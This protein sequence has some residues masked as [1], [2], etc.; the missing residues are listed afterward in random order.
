V[1][2]QVGLADRAREHYR[3]Y[4]LG[5][6]QRLA[7]GA[8][9]LKSPDLLILDEP[10]N[11]LDPAGIRSIRE[12]IRGLGETGTT[13]LLSSHILTEVQQV[14]HSVSILG[15]GRMLASGPVEELLGETVA[16]IR[17]GVSDPA[18]AQPVLEKAGHT[19]TRKGDLLLV[20]GP[21]RPEEITRLL[22]GQGIYVHEIAAVKPTLESFFLKLTGKRPEPAPAREEPDAA[23][24]PGD[25][26]EAAAE[27]EDE[28]AKGGTP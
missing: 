17:V 8:A 26:L 16:R 1:L 18:A 25:D 10:T 12:L 21:E 11:G 13:V 23:E 4:S 24:E 6:K 28:T 14:C 5:M 2:E 27:P 9:L 19:V 7:I 20:E 15:E 3:G 22:A